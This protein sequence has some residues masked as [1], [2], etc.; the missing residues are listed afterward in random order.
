VTGN[1]SFPKVAVR[2]TY[3][4][5]YSCV[6]TQTGVETRAQTRIKQESK[7]RSKSKGSAMDLIRDVLQGSYSH[8]SITTISE[9][10]FFPETG[11]PNY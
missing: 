7:S 5:T 8:L 1:I 11:W 9:D 2:N 4:A 6:E 3:S 10:A